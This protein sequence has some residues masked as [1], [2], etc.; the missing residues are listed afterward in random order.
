MNLLNDFRIHRAKDMRAVSAVLVVL[1]VTGLLGQSSGE[2]KALRE[3][4]RLVLVVASSFDAEAA[5][6][7]LFERAPNGE[8]QAASE[9]ESAVVGERGVAWW[10]TFAAYATEGEPV[11]DEP[12]LR[13]PAGIFPLGPSFGYGD[14]GGPWQINLEA[15]Q[16]YCVDDIASPLYNQIVAQEEAGEGVNGE[17][18]WLPNEYRRGLL[19]GYPTDIRRHPGSCI[20]VHVWTNPGRGTGGC[21][22]LPAERVE[23]IQRFAADVPTAIAIVPRDALDRF[24]G[25]PEVALPP[26]DKQLPELEVQHARFS[27]ATEHVGRYPPREH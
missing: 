27:S 18:M 13:S 20:F 1:L 23:A 6:V 4:Q 25:L 9:P 2:E 11:K 8:W 17:Q 7:Q 15:G 12:D 14:S 26:D 10:P 24:E 16:H 21:I 19:I 3:A 22:G 5:T